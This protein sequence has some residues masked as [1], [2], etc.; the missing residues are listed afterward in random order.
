MHD[1][2]IVIPDQLPDDFQMKF[3]KA[4]RKFNVNGFLYI[5]LIPL[6]FIA[7]EGIFPNACHT[8]DCDKNTCFLLTK[9]TAEPSVGVPNLLSLRDN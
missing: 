1:N 7:I 9:T 6:F 3:F 2:E 5:I 8:T 4:L